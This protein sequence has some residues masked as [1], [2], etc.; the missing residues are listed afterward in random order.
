MEKVVCH[1]WSKS[2]SWRD[3][4]EEQEEHLSFLIA[5]EIIPIFKIRIPDG[6]AKGLDVVT[7]S[8]VLNLVSGLLGG[9]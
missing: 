9:C 7:P 6:A 4:G 5:S 1:P 2:D 3:R 8:G